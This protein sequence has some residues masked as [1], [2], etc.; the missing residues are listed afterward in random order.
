[1]SII[2]VEGADYAGKTTT[3]MTIF[4]EESLWYNTVYI[5]FPIRDI[6]KDIIA[7]DSA[8]TSD[9]MVADDTNSRGCNGSFVECP[10]FKN[11]TMTEIQ[12]AILKNIVDNAKPIMRLWESGYRVIIDRYILSNLVYRY[13][14]HVPAPIIP[15]DESFTTLMSVAEHCILSPDSS[16]LLE[17][18]RSDT[19]CKTNDVLDEVNEQEDNIISANQAYHNWINVDKK[20]LLNVALEDLF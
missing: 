13:I 19:R 15:D 10:P 17:R 18:R 11:L 4:D 9:N 6:T 8:L 16:V 3:C 5:H 14:N 20:E 7:S 1:M 2:I 12:D